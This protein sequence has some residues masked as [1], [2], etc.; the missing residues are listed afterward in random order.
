L[1][2]V[3]LASLMIWLHPMHPLSTLGCYYISLVTLPD[4]VQVCA[5][6]FVTCYFDIFNGMLQMRR[7]WSAKNSLTAQG[8]R[9]WY[10]N[11]G[12]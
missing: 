11:T 8:V 9:E 5:N 4:M 7:W 2:S 3:W 10:T 6:E 12:L 1:S